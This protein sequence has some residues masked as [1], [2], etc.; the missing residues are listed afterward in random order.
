MKRQTELSA[1]PSQYSVCR[2]KCLE[3]REIKNQ[4]KKMEKAT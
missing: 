2:I 1:K 4:K 3:W